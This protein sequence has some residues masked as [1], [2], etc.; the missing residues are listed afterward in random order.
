[1]ALIKN[2][3]SG[4]GGGSGSIS[5]VNGVIS[6]F[7]ASSATVDANTFVEFVNNSTPTVGDG[8]SLRDAYVGE[9]SAVA[10]DSTRVF[11]AH[12][13]GT[14][15][16]GIIATINGNS[17]TAGVDTLLASGSSVSGPSA[18]KV[19][20]NSVFVAY[21]A[22]SNSLYGIVCIIDNNTITVGTATSL[23]SAINAGKRFSATRLSDIAVSVAHDYSNNNY[24]YCFICG[25]QGT[26]ITTGADTSISNQS[27]SGSEIYNVGLTDSNFYIFNGGGVLNGSACTRIGISNITVVD[28]KQLSSDSYSV[29]GSAVALDSTRAFI[30]YNYTSSFHIRG[31]VVRFDGSTTSSRAE[32]SI[33]TMARSFNRLS[34]AK[35]SADK[36]LVAYGYSSSNYLY[37]IS[38]NIFDTRIASGGN[39][40]SIDSNAGS[41]YYLSAVSNTNGA[42]FIAHR[43][44]NSNNYLYGTEIIDLLNVKP[45]EYMIEGVTAMQCTT[46]AAGNVW[47][48]NT[49]ESE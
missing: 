5:I 35:I 4:G 7:K 29:I 14:D 21:P 10:L 43:Q 1:M 28:T 25:V 18:V 45:A 38:C 20:T 12:N 32:Q 37:A 49:N 47:V 9:M 15:T 6:Q 31:A 44:N 26:S 24:L 33:M 16:Y 41:G 3:L 19:S 2:P 48:L 17:I 11:V 22:S 40:I 13:V 46:S 34:V 30:A 39:P 23:S 42:V 36:V 8:T 27:N